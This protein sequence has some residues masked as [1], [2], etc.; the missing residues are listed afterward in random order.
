[1]KSYLY[2]TFALFTL[3]FMVSVHTAS[4]QQQP[5]EPM[6]L[7]L[8]AEEEADKLQ[9]LLDL[10]DWQVFYVDS[11]LKANYAFL[12][13]EFDKL[14]KSKV[15]NVALYQAAQDKFWDMTEEVYKKYFTEE[16]W[17]TY[18]KNGAARAQ[19]QRAKRRA[20]ETK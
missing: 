2:M 16:Q 8:M 13:V 3:F 18:L 10:E 15:A 6:D 20:K 14:Q 7:N 1:M 11:T 5:Q 17:A 9:R 12:Q 19:K 4:A